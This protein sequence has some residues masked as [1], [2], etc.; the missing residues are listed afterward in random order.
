MSASY[1]RDDSTQQYPYHV[2][3]WHL[4]S[5]WKITKAARSR[6]QENNGAGKLSSTLVQTHQ[7]MP[8]VDEEDNRYQI[9]LEAVLYRLRYPRYLLH[10]R[11]SIVSS[12]IRRALTL[13]SPRNAM[14][15]LRSCFSKYYFSTACYILTSCSLAF[16]SISIVSTFRYGKAHKYRFSLSLTSSQITTENQHYHPRARYKLEEQPQNRSPWRL[17]PG[18]HH[19]DHLLQHSL[20]LLI[21]N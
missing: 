8:N 3:V 1:P 5:P 10:I 4:I 18:Q 12:T 14:G 17:S 20:N 11:A 13:F 7:H 19:L 2:S 21:Y 16:R 9:N 15:K 6:Q